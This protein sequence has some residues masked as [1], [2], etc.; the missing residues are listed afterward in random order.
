MKQTILFLALW[1]AMLLQ[2]TATDYTR[3]VNPFIGTQTDSTGALSGSTFPGATG[4]GAGESRYRTD[5]D[6][7]SLLGL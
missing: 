7:G 5:G 3:F 2:A 6:L 4:N 1:S